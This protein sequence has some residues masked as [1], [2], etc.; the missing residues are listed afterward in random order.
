MDAP[1]DVLGNAVVGRLRGVARPMFALD[2]PNEL[3][4]GFPLVLI[5]TFLVPLAIVLHIISLIQL[6]RVT[7]HTSREDQT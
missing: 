4:S 1:R 5:P 6:R 3:I 7:A 2:H